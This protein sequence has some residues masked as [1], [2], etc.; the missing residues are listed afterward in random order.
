MLYFFGCQHKLRRCFYS[1]NFFSSTSLL[2]PVFL[3]DNSLVRCNHDGSAIPEVSVYSPSDGAFAVTFAVDSHDAAVVQRDTPDFS[4][5]SETDSKL[6]TVTPSAPVA[7]SQPSSCRP[8]KA[9]PSGPV[10][11]YQEWVKGRDVRSLVQSKLSASAEA[12]SLKLQQNQE[13]ERRALQMFWRKDVNDVDTHFD[14]LG[15][16]DSVYK[17]LKSR[18][19]SDG[20]RDD[21]EMSDLL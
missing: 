8:T 3:K 21:D 14:I 1:S 10:D 5:S 11:A 15:K 17:K 4:R 20:A 13:D 16:N 6:T 19:H 2:F 9:A 7:R 18:A 12:R